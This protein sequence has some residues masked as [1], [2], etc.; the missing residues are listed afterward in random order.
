MLLFL[1]AVGSAQTKR[2]HSHLP[3]SIGSALGGVIYKTSCSF[4]FTTFN[5][6]NPWGKKTPPNLTNPTTLHPSPYL[7][8]NF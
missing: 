6:P 3:S 4:K 7:N 5:G 1:L 2:Y 8:S